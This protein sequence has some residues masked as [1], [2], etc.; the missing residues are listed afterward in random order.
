MMKSQ[1]ADMAPTTAEGSDVMATMQE[2]WRRQ[3]AQLS[4]FIT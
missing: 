2:M 3:F 1:V 4:M